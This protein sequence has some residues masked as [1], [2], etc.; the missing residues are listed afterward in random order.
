MGNIS[1]MSGVAFGIAATIGSL[2]M[3]ASQ[4]VQLAAVLGGGGAQASVEA[5]WSRLA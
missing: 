4:Y 2:D 3:T 5:R 1:G